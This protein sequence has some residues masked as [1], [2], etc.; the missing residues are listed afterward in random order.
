MHK[1][2]TYILYFT[3][4]TINAQ[5]GINTQNVHS[6]AVLHLESTTKGFL[7]PRL[8]QSQ[9]NTINNPAEGLLLYNTTLNYL[10]WFNG[11]QWVNPST[12]PIS[13]LIES[14]SPSINQVSI[15][16]TA[17]PNSLITGYDVFVQPGNYV[18]SGTSSPIVVPNLLENTLYSFS[19][20]ATTAIG[21]GMPSPVVQ[22]TTL[23]LPPG[24]PTK[25]DVQ[26]LNQKIIVSWDTS[27]GVVSNY[28]VAYK[29]VNATEWTEVSTNSNTIELSSLTN[30]ST[31]SI[32]VKA[33]NSAG[34]SDFT[35]TQYASPI[36]G[37]ILL[38]E[39]FNGTTLDGS[40]WYER[41]NNVETTT[42][43][44]GN[45]A[46]SNG[47]LSVLGTGTSDNRDML[48]TKKI[49]GKN[50]TDLIVQFNIVYPS[51]GN[52][53]QNS[54]KYGEIQ[55]NSSNGNYFR[56][57][58]TDATT[59]EVFTNQNS[60]T[61]SSQIVCTDNE[62]VNYKCIFK[63]NNAIEVYV[64]GVLNSN[65]T[66]SNVGTPNLS[67]YDSYIG[68]IGIGTNLFYVENITIS[69]LPTKPQRPNPLTSPIAVAGNSAAVV[70][71]IPP[72]TDG[73]S[74][75]INYTVTSTPGN[76]TAI[77]TSSPILV[78][79][80]TNGTSYTFKIVSNNFYGSSNSSFS[81]NAVIPSDAVIVPLFYPLNNSVLLQWK[82]VGDA[83]DYVIEYKEISASDWIVVNDGV[84]SNPQY[85]ITGLTN[86]IE[87][88]IRIKPLTNFA[89][90]NYS[91]VISVTPTN[92]Y[93]SNCWNQIVS[94]GQSLS[95]GH[96]GTPALSTTQP[97]SNKQLN[98]SFTAL[99]PLVELGTERMYSSLANSI[100]QQVGTTNP[101]NSIVTLRGVGATP[102][103]GLKKGTTTYDYIINAIKQAKK[104]SNEIDL[105]PYVIRAL[106]V[107][108]GENDFANTQYKENL[109]EWQ[110]DFETD[111][112]YISGQVGIIPMFTCQVST[113]SIYG[114]T[115]PVSALGQLDAALENPNKI[116]LVTPKYFLDY[117]D[118]L[119][120]KNFSYK[121]L[122]EYY[123][124]V[125]KK[126]LVDKQQWLPLYATQATRVGNTITVDFHVPVAPLQINTTS[127][128]QQNHFGFEYFD[129]EQSANIVNVAIGT[130]GTSVIITL[131][132]E[133]NGSNKKI[134][135]AYTGIPGQGAGRE[136]THSTKG[137]LCDSDATPMLFSSDYPGYYGTTLKNWC[138][139]FIKNVN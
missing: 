25:F 72:L 65:L 118:G 6:S 90:Y 93:N 31:Y 5:V 4:L 73:G 19:L 84:S 97:Y 108:H 36:S 29:E 9:I 96:G 56:L 53:S 33:N 22:S 91:S 45:I 117:A 1:V 69:G 95:V 114:G 122:G 63:Q 48:R 17:S 58:K 85:T 67:G 64:N 37:E 62:V 101:F 46:I 35:S 106:T 15:N 125:M 113:W 104:I 39:S 8:Q 44:S 110:N 3:V 43:A 109:L 74:P 7:L 23:F 111:L 131:S 59:L 100:S 94:T 16:F 137:N 28:S 26:P 77:G 68:F 112:K 129:D 99:D 57:K 80:L 135:Y 130:N 134:A 102:Y 32:K 50:T 2:I 89:I 47:R 132:N 138:V 120:L 75:I 20:M 124:K 119:H 10:D 51:C 88:N 128:L 86:G 52:T 30:N 71:F 18:V 38:F 121:L 123:G 133:P 82:G 105:K 40:L 14:I 107:V 136:K 21:K 103:S 98:S 61:K 49:F 41:E 13:P 81:T 127:L 139:S 87:Y 24:I 11:Q 42:F 60:S 27:T 66:Y 115:K 116:V 55:N 34:S 78:T 92:D 79:G 76:I 83:I 126:V 12:R 70:N 54:F